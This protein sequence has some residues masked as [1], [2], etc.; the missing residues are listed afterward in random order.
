[1]K[2]ITEICACIIP[3]LALF[4]SAPV[5]HAEP[6]FVGIMETES[7]AALELSVS[8]FANVTRIP[9]LNQQLK[10]KTAQLTALPALEG[11]ERNRRIRII[12]IIDPS[13]PLSDTNPAHIAVI[14]IGDGGQEIERIFSEHYLNCTYWRSNITLYDKPVATNLAALVAVAKEGRFLLTSRS[15]EALLWICANTKLLN[16]PPLVQRGTLKFLIN[17]QRSAALLNAQ[18]DLTL[19]RL[20]KPVEILQELEMC[21]FALTL[22]S[23][24]LTVTAEA[25]LLEGTPLRALAKK[26]QPPDVTLLNSVPAGAFL[27]SISRCS[28][29]E[30]WNRFALNLR[31]YAV[32][33][34]TGLSTQE[35]FTGERV[36]YLAPARD[37]KGFVFIQ[38][39]PLKDAA[40]VRSAIHTLAENASPASLVYLEK[41]PAEPAQTAA[42]LCYKIRLRKRDEQSAPSAIYAIASL[43]IEHA[44]LELEIKD[45]QLITVIGPRNSLGDFISTLPGAPRTISLLNEIAVRNEA[46]QQSLVSGTKLELTGLLRFAASLIPNITQEQ[47]AILPEGG[48]GV[49]FGLIREKDTALRGSLQISAD[50]LAALKNIG[51]D[52]RELMQRLLMSMLVKRIEHM[53]LPR[54]KEQ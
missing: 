35:L 43:F 23:Q 48:Y 16:A 26:L 31:D 38:I 40:A 36:H 14:P 53:E 32:P 33:S 3:L 27:T 17:P 49:T 9:E 20:F 4:G 37:R 30:L 11:F 42:S 22:E 5:G 7:Y 29:P 39:E 2:P 24:S 12:Q 41:M 1:M 18:G 13:E 45:N 34:L 8:A 10:A 54:E 46:L 52:G 6:L 21:S 19:L 15:K 28:D 25:A 44:Y 47:L 50:E 51:T